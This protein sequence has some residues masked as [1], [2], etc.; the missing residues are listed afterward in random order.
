MKKRERF[1]L[2]EKSDPQINF[3]IVLCLDKDMRFTYDNELGSFGWA[4]ELRCSCFLV[5]GAGKEY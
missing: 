3:T 1:L 5:V 2:N 4:S